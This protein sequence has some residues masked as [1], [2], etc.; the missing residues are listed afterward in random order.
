MYAD[1]AEVARSTNAAG[2]NR[3]EGPLTH[4]VMETLNRALDQANEIR[5]RLY[6]LRD[7][8]MGSPPPD[9][10]TANGKQVEASHFKGA[11]ADKSI[12]LLNA[13]ADI[14]TVSA[15]LANRL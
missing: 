7:R 12:M 2:A 5:H 15:D 4:E 6:Q 14:D 13:M 8:L 11:H 9:P 10:A 3:V 1:T